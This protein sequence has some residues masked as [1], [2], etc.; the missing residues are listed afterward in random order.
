MAE[1]ISE[2]EIV[3]YF[4]QRGL[5]PYLFHASSVPLRSV[6]LFL[7]FPADSHCWSAPVV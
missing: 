2:S 6:R 4:N 5:F 3:S 1:G 7:F